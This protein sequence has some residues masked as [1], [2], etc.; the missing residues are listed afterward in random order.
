MIRIEQGTV[1]SPAGFR[2]AGVAAG[3]KGDGKRD[4]ALI[5]SDTEANAAG[6]YTKNTVKGHSLQLTRKHMAG[7]SLKAVVIN[8]G[9]ANACVGE[10]GELAAL[11]I[12]EKAAGLAG[13]K[14][15][16]I[17]IGSTGVIGSPLPEDRILSGLDLAFSSLSETGGHEAELAIMTTDTVPKECAVRT[18]IGGKEITVGGIAKGSGMIHPNMGTMIS[19]LTTDASV[20][21]PVLDSVLHA[22]TGVTF[23]RVSVDGDMSVCDMCLLLANG[24]AGNA[25]I[26]DETSEEAAQLR[27][28]VLTVCDCLARGLAKDGEGATKLIEV[29][30]KNA[31]TA[32]DAHKAAEAIANSPLC[33]TA[34]FGEDANC[35]RILTAVGYSGAAFDPLAV[36]LYLGSLKTYENGCALPFS[37]E[38]ALAILKK[39]EIGV[40]VDLKAG[41]FHDKMWTCDFSYDYVK[42]NGSYRS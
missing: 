18:R 32:E 40:T 6:V 20:S 34:F 23:N 13:T 14:A 19:V 3:I 35:G 7:G 24:L 11:R 8:S 39:D 28:A 12:C 16:R 17:A 21:A 25:E 15:D 2:A 38:E 1:T 5:V 9:C 36:D 10:A 4:L 26:T 41:D 31:R 27:E 22:V 29:T 30:V 33:K 42:I 37:E